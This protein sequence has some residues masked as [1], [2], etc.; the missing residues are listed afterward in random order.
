[1]SQRWDAVFIGSG[2]GSLTCGAFLAK[3]G[4]KVRVLERHYRIGGYAHSFNRNPY[5]FESGI[6]SVPFGNGGYIDLL[7][8]TLGVRDK[9]ETI[10]HGNMYSTRIGN[11]K[12]FTM[13][14]TEEEIIESLSREFPHEQSAIRSLLADMGALY[15][16][17]IGPLYDFKP[18]GNETNPLILK[19][20]LD[21]TYKSYIES[22]IN[23]PKLCNIFFGQWPFIGLTPDNAATTFFT[24]LFYVHVAEGNHYLKGGFETL[25]NALASVITDNGGE[26]STNTTVT[27]LHCENG[28]V[29]HAET[30]S[31]EIIEGSH[32][33]SNTSPHNLLDQLLSKNEVSRLWQKRVHNLTCS[34]SSVVV[35]LG[36]DENI[37]HMIPQNILFCYKDDNFAKINERIYKSAPAD[38]DHLI[39]L[40]TP[41]ASEQ[42]TLFLM[43]FE[44]YGNS[45]DWKTDKEKIADSMMS[46]AES[47]FPGLSSHIK[48]KV[49]ASPLTFE[50]Y[51]NNT[52]GSLYGFANIADR[53]NEAKIP[54]QTYIP[55]L[56]QA[57]HWCRGA[58][59]WN[60]MES[61]H[62]VSDMILSKCR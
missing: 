4:M 61:G 16:N 1:M 25:A 58:G 60:V 27:H 44:K 8:K 7:L 46:D 39:V 36:L 11:N 37:S 40:K 41:E 33:I 18:K 49:T 48:C 15:K 5:R 26:I 54:M 53:Y 12:L 24:L 62:A 47:F 38:D 30:S 43:R 10:P 59:V 6:H 50:R 13:P 21:H 2:I 14:T 35:Y 17:V 9:V 22:F 23:D 3:A 31:G 51:T 57:G 19:K 29:R 32:F 52:R 55:N 56:Y 42:P 28:I 34:A 45:S 20:Y